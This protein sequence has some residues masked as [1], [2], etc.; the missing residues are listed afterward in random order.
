M[1]DLVRIASTPSA[2]LDTTPSTAD[3]APAATVHDGEQHESA[4]G[5]PQPIPEH[6]T[7][8]GPS[9]QP[10]PP[11]PVT[12]PAVEPPALDPVPA[13]TGSQV[14]SPAMQQPNRLVPSAVVTDAAPAQM[15]DSVRKAMRLALINQMRAINAAWHTVET[16]QHDLIRGLTDAN[17]LGFPASEIERLRGEALGLGFQAEDFDSLLRHTGWTREHDVAARANP[18]PAPTTVSSHS[19]PAPDQSAVTPA[20]RPDPTVHDAP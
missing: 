3:N 10:A 17:G 5:R 2:Y 1:T 9:P 7:T 19:Q 11:D 6:A 12:H 8:E 20:H 4:V 13:R 15:P 14:A 18:P 16:R